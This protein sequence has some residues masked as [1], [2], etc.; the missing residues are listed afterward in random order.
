MATIATPV[1]SRTENGRSM[2]QKIQR[3]IKIFCD[4]HDPQGLVETVAEMAEKGMA[5]VRAYSAPQSTIYCVSNLPLSHK[6]TLKAL[7]DDDA[8]HALACLRAGDSVSDV[9]LTH[10]LCPAELICMAKQERIEMAPGLWR[11]LTPC[12]P[13][14]NPLGVFLRS[15]PTHHFRFKPRM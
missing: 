11:V 8:A 7:R 13:G 9:F 2:K 10:G 14:E 3:E 5:C 4:R 6:R 12:G 15:G 1:Q